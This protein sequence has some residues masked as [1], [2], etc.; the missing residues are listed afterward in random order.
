[1]VTVMSVT[2]RSRAALLALVF[3]LPVACGDDNSSSSDSVAT[4]DVSVTVAPVVTEAPAPTT[5]QPVEQWDRIVAPPDCMCSDASE[6]ALFVRHASASKVLLFFQGGGACFDVDGCDPTSGLYLPRV[7]PPA[8]LGTGKGI[9]DFD[10][11]DNPFADFSV[12]F[13]PYCT[14]DVH[15]GNSV[16]DYGVNDVGSEVI[17]HHNGYVNGTQAVTTLV[18]LFPDADQIVVAGESAGGVP[19]PLYAGLVHD[20]LADARI[21]VIADGSGAYPDVPSINAFIGGLWGTVNA[22]PDWPENA[23]ATAENWSLPGL[24]VRASAHDPAITFA[25][26]DYAFDK[27]QAFFGALAGVDADQL[28]TLIDLNETQIEASGATLFSFI[29]PGNAHTVLSKPAFYTETLDGTSL[30]D[31]VAALVAGTPVTDVHC[32][33]C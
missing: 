21:T 3:L 2:T 25:R 11:P 27:T 28:V 9:F 29:S 17:V 7:L 8:A 30:R 10:N 14:G 22:I 4:T 16:H 13:V 23:D 20:Q 19:T 31:W 5:T 12:V 6:F 33:E 24:F 18:E 15:L 1:M 26:H 32:T